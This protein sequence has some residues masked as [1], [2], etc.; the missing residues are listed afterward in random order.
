MKS[1][2]KKGVRPLSYFGSGLLFMAALASP[3]AGSADNA[4]VNPPLDWI[5]GNWCANLDGISAEELWQPPEDG[6]F[7]GVGQTRQS[8]RTSVEYLRIADT[9]G[10]Q[11]YIAGPA[12]QRPTTFKRTAGGESW[13]RFENPAHDFPQRIEYRREGDR[14]NAEIAG[15]DKNGEEAVYVFDFGPCD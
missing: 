11:S 5:V 8:G 3:L 13:V 15:P 4:A 7:V 1:K 9:N 6:V 2:S 10:V 14:L 12:G